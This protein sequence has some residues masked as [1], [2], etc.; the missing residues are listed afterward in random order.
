MNGIFGYIDDN[1]LQNRLIES[2]IRETMP[3]SEI[4]LKK[5]E[6]FLY[7]YSRKTEKTSI[8]SKENEDFLIFLVGSILNERDLSSDP[9][10]YQI[11]FENKCMD[12]INI[13][14]GSFTGI[15]F[16]KKL[17]ILYAFTDHCSNKNLYWTTEKNRIFFGNELKY[18]S[19]IKN[20]LNLINYPDYNAFYSMLS[21]GYMIGSDTYIKDVRKLLPGQ[22]IK[23]DLLSHSIE[24][25]NYFKL[26][27]SPKLDMD[28]ESI[29]SELSEKFKQTIR[30]M[31]DYDK[32][33]TDQHLIL[34]SGGLDSRLVVGLAKK[35][36]IDNCTCLNFAQ[37]FSQDNESAQQVAEKLNYDYIFNSLNHG[38]YLKKN[39]DKIIYANEGLVYFIGASHIFDSISK[40]NMSNYGLV[41][42]GML[43]DGFYG[44][45]FGNAEKDIW[46]QSLA[47]FSKLINKIDNIS[48]YCENYSNYEEFVLYN[49]GI[50]AITNGLRMIEYFSEFS[51]P[52]MDWKLADFSFK[53]PDNL[54]YKNG[55]KPYP[56]YALI[57][58]NVPELKWILYHNNL[59]PVF[60]NGYIIPIF[61]LLNNIKKVLINRP[62]FSQNPFKKW[63][64][65]NS[66]LS[67]NL[68]SIF[69]SIFDYLNKGEFKNDILELYQNSNS[70]MVKSK[71]I[72]AVKSAILHHIVL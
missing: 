20:A 49:R 69:Y 5:E 44:N 50:N 61:H 29:I 34:L 6:K 30:I 25:G 72:T 51:Y 17:N 70:V 1:I 58:K 27:N 18:I 4:F 24:Q 63:M 31:F 11:E 66:S 39:I 32:T 8:F 33:Y 10:W 21:I 47:N 26:K 40:V 35:M 62:Y 42:S 43:M 57:L 22:Y 71:C 2:Q 23:I 60:N 7:G 48:N 9:E 28:A 38:N 52:V 16:L 53:I 56:K 36:S 14:I 64:K 3:I 68:D 37:S 55:L 15:I 67:E 19:G 46:V 41:H 59:S 54:K 65:E 13:F 12:I 45:Y